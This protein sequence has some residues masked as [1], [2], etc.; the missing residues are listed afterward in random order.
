[1]KFF[2]L[3]FSFFVTSHTVLFGQTERIARIEKELSSTK[4]DSNKVLKYNDLVWFYLSSDHV[5]TQRYI[6]EGLQLTTKIGFKRGEML[7]L[8]RLSD[9]HTH[10]GDYAKA[11]EVATQSLRIAEQIKD[12]IGIADAYIQLG[13]IHGNNFKQYETSLDYHQRALV[14]YEKQK[15]LNGVAASYNMIAHINAIIKKDTALAIRYATNAVELARKYNNEDFLGWCITTK[16]IVYSNLSQLDSALFFLKLAIVHYEKAQDVNNLIINQLLIGNI[17]IKQNR[18]K[19]AIIIFQKQVA[20]TR[21]LNTIGLLRD[22]YH[23]L[24]DSYALLN[25]HDSAYRYH[26]KYEHLKDSLFNAETAK[27]ITSIQSNYEQEKQ[28]V[29]IA[30]LEK[31]KQLAEEEKLTYTVFFGGSTVGLLIIILLIFN[32]NREKKKTNLLLQ[33]KKKEIEVQ[34]EEL[35]QSKEE[36]AQQRDTV[37]LQNRQL[38]KANDTKDKL[39]SI[40]SHDLRSPI[41]SLRNLFDLIAENRISVNDFMTIFFP[42]LRHSVS[43][44]YDTLDNLLQWSYSQMEG[45]KSNP[46]KIDIHSVIFDTIALFKEI[47]INKQITITPKVQ[48][49]ISAYADLNQVRLVMRNLLNNAI[50]FTLAQGMIAISTSQQEGFV[51]IVV[52]DTGLGM[53]ENQLKYLFDPATRLSTRGTSGERGTGLGLILCKEMIES[54]GGSIRVESTENHGST[55]VVSLPISKHLLS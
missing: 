19:E 45:I 16:G 9:L 52:K 37:A 53:T 2:V 3:I 50:K 6:N 25:Q 26:V 47:A 17:Y 7:L 22:A 49:G 32:N 14:I 11:I 18:A 54:N 1:M 40:I 51:E 33:E 15:S 29:R 48:E 41:G 12:S 8:N 27:K 35:M 39:F 42:K 23:G 21:K 10:Q 5:K 46:E 30:L 34:N 13:I 20:E 4:E 28:E 43:S 36:I 44:L 24:S 38:Q 55:F 31:E